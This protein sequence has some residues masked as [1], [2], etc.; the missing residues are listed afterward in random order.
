MNAL[1]SEWTGKLMMVDHMSGLVSEAVE[2][3]KYLRSLRTTGFFV[4]TFSL[5]VFSQSDN[6]H[7]R[8]Q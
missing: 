6:F 3:G 1:P 7:S 5:V 4:W 2:N 8:E